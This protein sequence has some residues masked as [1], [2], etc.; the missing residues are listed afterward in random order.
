MLSPEDIKKKTGTAAAAL[1]PSGATVGIG[2]GSTAHWLIIALSERIQQGLECRAV[3]TS[4]QTALLAAANNIP[5]L[6]LNEAGSIQ[7]TIDGADEIDPQ[8]QL[9]KGG[10]GALLQEKMV[11]AASDQLVIIADHSKLVSQLGAFPLPVELVPYNWKQ[12]QRRIEKEHSITTSLRK[13]NDQPFITD[14]GHYILDCSFQRITD[15]RALDEALRRIP[16]LVETGL[17]IGMA[18]QALIG[19]PD[20]RVEIRLPNR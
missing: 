3:P 10:G 13:K 5:L 14:H 15:A 18:T 6:A 1:V 19:Y 9:I 7:L 2:T 12:V 20:G 8:F 4:Q 11:A 16:G 17:F